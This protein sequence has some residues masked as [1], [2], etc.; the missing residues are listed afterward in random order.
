[1]A[2][3]PRDAFPKKHVRGLSLYDLPPMLVARFAVDRRFAGRGLEH[4]LISEAFRIGLRVAEEVGCRCIVTDAYRTG[5][6][7]IR[8]MVLCPSK[9]LW[10]VG[11]KGC[12]LTCGRSARPSG[13]ESVKPNHSP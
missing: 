4:A 11:H 2:S 10:R 13:A 5:S 8:V 12:F 7:G 1:M 3:V 6:V 9:V